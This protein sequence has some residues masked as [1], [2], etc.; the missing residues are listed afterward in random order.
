MKMM[1][2]GSLATKPDRDSGWIREFSN[3][4][5]DVVSFGSDCEANAKGVIGKIRRRLHVGHVNCEMRRAL[6]D[7]IAQEKPAWVHFRLPINFD[8]HTILAIKK[9]VPVV[10]QYF[11]DDPFS[12]KEPFGLYWKFRKALTTYDG[13]FV[14]RAHNISSYQSSGAKFV[15]HCPPAYT[16]ARHCLGQRLP[17]GK[18]IADVAFIGHCEGDWRVDCLDTLYESGLKV[19][20]KGGMWDK[21]IRSRS[22]G[23]LS[24]INHA[25]GEEYNYIYSNV[26]AGLCFFSKINRD[27]WTERALEI[28]A[29]GGVLVC[30]RTAEATTYFTDREE[31]YFF[32]TIDELIEIVAELKR[33]PKT[34]ERVRQAGH[35]RLLAG[36]HTIRDRAAQIDQFVR[37][38]PYQSN[39][40]ASSKSKYNIST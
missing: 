31:A 29:V 11:N 30:E 28:I 38:H 40:K 4:G 19:I 16:P 39:L 25:F 32:S 12:G 36:A 14:Y 9:I 18:F 22:I 1:Y 24:P 27:T 6:L 21:A 15:A 23:E 34:R 26:I 17:S 7:L 10:T 35:R 3:L 20:L 2:I 13:N 33:D 37:T 8:R 5:W